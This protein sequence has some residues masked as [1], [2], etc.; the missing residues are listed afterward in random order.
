MK[1]RPILLSLLLSTATLG[2][3]QLGGVTLA[4][5]MDTGGGKLLLNGMAVRKKVIFKVYVAGLYLPAREAS[6]EAILAGD[7]PR[8]C[9]LHFVRKVEGGKVAG[10]WR[11]GLAANT[12]DASA[13]LKQQFATLCGWMEEMRDGELLE[14]IYLPG[15][16]T[17]VRVKGKSKGIL[18]GK[19]F[20]DAL[21]ACWIGP[22]PGPGEGFKRGLLGK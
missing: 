19:P 4:D 21:F 1:L 11:D 2:A 17:E 15:R 3:A 12:P 18:P 10:A 16:G 13:E 5:S 7:T 22:R 6:G 14:F 8:A 20:A 9:V